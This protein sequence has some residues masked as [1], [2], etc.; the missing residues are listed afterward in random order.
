M[1][2]L[3]FVVLYVPPMVRLCHSGAIVTVTAVAVEGTFLMVT[4]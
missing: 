1:V 3:P 4:S 2:L